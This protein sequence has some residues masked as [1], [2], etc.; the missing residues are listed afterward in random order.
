[1]E[2]AERLDGLLLTGGGDI[3]PRYYGQKLETAQDLTEPERDAFEL[4]LFDLMLSAQKPMLGICRGMQ[5]IAVACGAQ[6]IQ[7]VKGHNGGI[8]HDID[9][10]DG[11]F[12]KMCNCNRASV[13][14]YH[15]QA[16]AEFS[17]RGIDTYTTGVMRFADGK[18]ASFHLVG[19]P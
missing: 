6:L 17:D 4:A 11:V 18:K 5:L 12:K 16:V 3:T 10:Y 19:N 14:S 13:N 7:E 15:M 9:I 1:M 2:I 8:S